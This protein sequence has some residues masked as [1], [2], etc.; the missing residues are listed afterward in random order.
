MRYFG[1][2]RLRDEREEGIEFGLERLPLI[3]ERPDL[4]G[5]LAQ[6]VNRGLFLGPLEFRDLLAGDLAPIAELFDLRE[7]YLAE[8]IELDEPIQID[9]D[10]LPAS[11]FAHPLEVCA[12]EFHVEHRSPS[13]DGRRH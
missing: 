2:G 9:L 3:I 7:V 11:T 12:D 4:I 6:R 10:P 8:V 5:N 13:F 1:I